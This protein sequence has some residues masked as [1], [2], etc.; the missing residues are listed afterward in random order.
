ML[1]TPT[2]QLAGFLVLLPTG[3]C[4]YKSCPI[5]NMH[6]EGI[7]PPI[8]RMASSIVRRCPFQAPP[9]GS[10]KSWIAPDVLDC[11]YL[12]RGQ[13][14]ETSEVSVMEGV[15]GCTNSADNRPIA[16]GELAGK[17]EAGNSTCQVLLLS[18]Q[19]RQISGFP[20]TSR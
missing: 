16:R 3:R 12:N 20:R 9:L 5:N 14:L 10:G 4:T 19:P 2:H 1:G 6:G 17:K 8:H 13:H 11:Y 15:I 18:K 7:E